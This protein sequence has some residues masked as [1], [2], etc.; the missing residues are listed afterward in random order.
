MHL[1]QVNI[2]RFRYPLDDL[3]AA[4]FV[5]NLDRI[6][7][8]AE[9]SDGFVWRLKGETGN[10]TEISAYDDPAILINMS[11]WRSVEALETFVY[12][13]VHRRFVQRRKE[14]FELFGAAYL[15][16][17]WVEEGAFPDAAE[18]RR[19]V[20]HLERFGPTPFAFS[21]KRRFPPAAAVPVAEI[22]EDSALPEPYR[23]CG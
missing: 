16:L 21:F 15:A 18:G 12:R 23:P 20:T 13:T 1:A 10:A 14:W 2:G 11:V 3:R 17:W 19:R 9:E 8:L 22:G 4:D 7:A 5:D 6:N